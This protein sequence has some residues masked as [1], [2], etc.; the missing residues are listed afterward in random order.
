MDRK[1]FV[2]LAQKASLY[3]KDNIPAEVAVCYDGVEYIPKA[4]LL[5]FRN[6][7]PMH[8]CI[9]LDKNRNSI[10]EASLDRIEHKSN[11][12]E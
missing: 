5:G 12:G 9:L 2:Q 8:S 10:V 7:E 4:Y 1:A 3:E 6:G 11:G